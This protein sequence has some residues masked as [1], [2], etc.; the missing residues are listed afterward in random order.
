MTKENEPALNTTASAELVVSDADLA[1]VLSLSGEDA[2]P[3][4]FATS[5]MIAL[6]EVASA[7]LLL[8]YLGPGELS[9]GTDVEVVHTAAT[10]LGVT[11]SAKARYLGRDGKLFVFEVI[12]SDDG[13]EIGRGSHKRAIVSTDRLLSGA[14]RRNG[15]A[16]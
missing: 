6:M 5:R 3:P 13:G 15:K 7:R 11:V 1:S 10:P 16:Y 9:V 12:A 8:P 4:V 2:Y 14:A